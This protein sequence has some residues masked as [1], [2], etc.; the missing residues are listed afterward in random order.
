[1]TRAR[2]KLPKAT[3]PKKN[4]KGTG[5][6]R[7]NWNI[8]IG[9][10]GLVAVILAAIISP[11]VAEWL[12]RKRVHPPQLVEK[13]K[14]E[15]LE[16]IARQAEYT[17]SPSDVAHQKTTAGFYLDANK[18]ISD[19]LSNENDSA[20]SPD[21][22][23]L[24]GPAG[25]GKSTLTKLFSGPTTCYV[26]LKDEFTKGK[27]ASYSVWQADLKIG[28]TVFNEMRGLAPQGYF[29]LSGFLTNAGC[30][31]LGHCQTLA[32]LDDLDELHPNLAKYLLQLIE[33]A[34][35]SEPR[36]L[37][38]KRIVVVGRPEGF[39]YY[40]TEHTR[41][42]YLNLKIQELNLPQYTSK[43]DLAVVY[44]NAIRRRPDRPTQTAQGEQV[45][46]HLIAS[47]GWLSYTVSQLSYADFLTEYVIAGKNEGGRKLRDTLFDNILHYNFQSHHR[48]LNANEVY[49]NLLQNIAV[50]YVD[51][52]IKNN[53]EFEV[54]FS[55]YIPAYSD[56][57]NQNKIG[58][59]S[60]QEVLNRSGIAYFRPATYRNT[61]YYFKPQWLHPYL[62]ERW[63][64]RMSKNQ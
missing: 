3:G 62:V 11:I 13:E 7:I 48:P 31:R 8:I 43:G 59:I 61:K 27:S 10:A 34:F 9:L 24:T 33:T 51:E 53:G 52:A 12:S 25:G 26:D 19:L 15:Q 30:C 22:I 42:P 46:T 58:T 37:L 32:I 41:S 55:A 44:A 64:E 56:D 17:I 16:N 63:N 60:I 28:D 35:M 49:V 57:K 1:M 20:S 29:T 47:E 45:F 54:A 14:I 21:L 39:F 2:K 23:Y 50:Q 40:L 4:P 38:P 5:P 6:K 18:E 36:P